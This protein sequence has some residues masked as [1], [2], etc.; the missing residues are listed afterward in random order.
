MRGARTNQHINEHI[1]RN[2]FILLLAASHLLSSL[3]GLEQ[4]AGSGTW[5]YELGWG[6]EISMGPG[7]VH[8]WGLVPVF[9]GDLLR[10]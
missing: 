9:C 8:T 6:K 7:V 3:L 4:V 10:I 2:L 5:G 1:S